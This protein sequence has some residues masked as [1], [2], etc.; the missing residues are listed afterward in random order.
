MSNR[1]TAFSTTLLRSPDARSSPMRP[2]SAS[3]AS[4]P[5]TVS[6][7]SSPSDGSRSARRT[8]IALVIGAAAPS[9]PSPISGRRNRRKNPRRLA[10]CVRA[11]RGELEGAS[12]SKSEARR[13]GTDSPGWLSLRL[14]SLPFIG[15]SFSRAAPIPRLPMQFNGLH[16]PCRRLNA[17][18]HGGY[19]GADSRATGPMFPRIGAINGGRS[20]RRIV[21][22]PGKHM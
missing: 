15:D 3:S 4:A 10:E 13:R 21:R 9:M 2:A 14:R 11:R 12:V 19:T 20:D 5:A 16:H 8:S 17:V 6:L 1:S 22:V 7:S 18:P